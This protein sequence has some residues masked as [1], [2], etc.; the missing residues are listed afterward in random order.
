MRDLPLTTCGAGTYKGLCILLAGRP[1]KLSL[2]K[3]KGAHS[4]WMAGQTRDMTPLENLGANSFWDEQA[5]GWSTSWVWFLGLSYCILKFPSYSG[6][7]LGTLNNGCDR[8]FLV[9]ARVYSRQ[10]IWLEIF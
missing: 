7:Y 1:P 8:V 4:A 10:S 9:A 5:V 6:H 3:F 2:E